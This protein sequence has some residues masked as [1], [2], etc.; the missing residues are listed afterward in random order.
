VLSRREIE[1][2]TFSLPAAT[3]RTR[4]YRV[5]IQLRTIDGTAQL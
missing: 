3:N 5:V 1:A 4:P 2:F